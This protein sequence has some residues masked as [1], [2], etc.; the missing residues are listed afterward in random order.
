MN[1]EEVV[2]MIDAISEGEIYTLTIP[3][4]NGSGEAEIIFTPSR[5]YI[6]L[7]EGWGTEHINPRTAKEIVG[8]LVAWAK[9]KEGLTPPLKNDMSELELKN[10]ESSTFLAHE[11]FQKV[12]GNPTAP[13]IQDWAD[14]K[15]GR[16]TRAEWYERNIKRMTQETKNQNL[17]DLRSIALEHSDLDVDYD[18]IQKAIRVLRDAGATEDV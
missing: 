9:R 2:A 6:K 17:K 16:T 4:D 1:T 14:I 3:G 15:A 10:V 7:T 12:F 8:A 5:F 11:K 13:S 18:D